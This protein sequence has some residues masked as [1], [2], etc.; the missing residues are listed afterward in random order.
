M[1]YLDDDLNGGSTDYLFEDNEPEDC[2]A[3]V[4]NIGGSDHA[5]C[6]NC[7]AVIPAGGD[8]V[9]VV[10]VSAWKAARQLTYTPEAARSVMAFQEMHDAV[11][12]RFFKN[13]AGCGKSPAQRFHEGGAR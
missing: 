5:H 6:E 7:E 12:R 2:G 1:S 8:G 3:L 11:M 13:G 4:C 10:C 9:C